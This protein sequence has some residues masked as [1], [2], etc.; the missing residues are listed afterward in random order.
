MFDDSP[1]TPVEQRAAAGKDYTHGTPA[2]R[3]IA[4]LLGLVLIAIGVIAGRD[5][6]MIAKEQREDQAWI[7]PALDYVANIKTLE[8]W[9][10]AVFAVVGIV[11][12]YLVLAALKPRP[13]TTIRLDATSAP[14]YMRPLDVARQCTAVTE[15]IAGVHKART[16]VNRKGTK[17]TVYAA[18]PGAPADLEESIHAAV[19]QHVANLSSRPR[20][21][22]TLR[23]ELS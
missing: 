8:P 13:K 17:V 14:V 19:S 16:V 7:R 2:V 15:R 10:L 21:K 9:M 6:W 18:A 5:L 4:S 12:L 23:K 20:V 1:N 22:V 3:T 11:G